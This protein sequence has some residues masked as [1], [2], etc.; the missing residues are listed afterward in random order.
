MLTTILPS[1]MEILTRNFNYRNK[2]VKLYEL[3][4]IYFG[5]PD[6]LADEPKILSMGAYGT[7]M[8]FYKFKGDV[9]G[10]L[11]IMRLPTT[12]FTSCTDNGSY[13]PR[14]CA[15]IYCRGKKLG[16]M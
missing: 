3:G 14:R 13:H 6:G 11:S 9:E 8:D 10:T 2:D 7:D 12:S 5:R 15:G 4:K 1:M 16:V